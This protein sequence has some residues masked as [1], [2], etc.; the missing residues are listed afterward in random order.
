VKNRGKKVKISMELKRGL[1][2]KGNVDIRER[3]G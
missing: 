2:E 3:I 1:K